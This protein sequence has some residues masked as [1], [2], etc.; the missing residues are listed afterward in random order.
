MLKFWLIQAFVKILREM[1]ATFMEGM[2]RLE[3]P[4]EME[5]RG[6]FPHSPECGRNPHYDTTRYED[7][8]ITWLDPPKLDAIDNFEIVEKDEC[9]STGDSW[10]GS[11]VVSIT[12]LKCAYCGQM[13][14]IKPK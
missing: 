4:T 13:Q 5:A 14:H 3:V 1:E 9:F 7:L 8:G 12:Y 10:I 11:G 2:K 6:S